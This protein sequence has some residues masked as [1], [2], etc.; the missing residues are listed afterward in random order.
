MP[1]KAGP[2]FVAAAGFSFDSAGDEV[3]PAEKAFP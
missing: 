1:D 3:A 2:H